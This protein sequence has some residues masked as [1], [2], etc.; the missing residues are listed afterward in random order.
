MRS[1]VLALVPVL[2]V[3]TA[4]SQKE[5]IHAESTGA[6]GTGGQKMQGAGGGP[7]STTATTGAG[8]SG[9]GSC[10]SEPVHVAGDV[11]IVGADTDPKQQVSGSATTTSGKLIQ[12]PFFLTDLVGGGVAWL[13]PNGGTCGIQ[14]NPT[15]VS[16]NA[17]DNHGL[18]VFVPTG[19][20]LCT[21]AEQQIWFSGFR[22]Y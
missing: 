14:V 13:I 20:T 10:C 9:A 19:M 4:C 16:S 15:V 2:V 17:G 1:F 3:L 11:K 7:S 6:S 12:G 21:V 22:P 18:R 8:G 5:S